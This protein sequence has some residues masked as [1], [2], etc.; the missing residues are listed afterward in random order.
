[1]S[2]ILD[3]LFHPLSNAIMT[4]LTGVTALYWITTF[5]AGDLFGDSG[6]DR[7]F[8]V[9]GADL[10]TDVAGDSDEVA[11]DQSFVQKALEFVNVG[12]VPFMMVYS[13]FK[14]VA[15]IITLASSVVLG[16]ASWGWKS[17]LTLIPVFL[18]AYVITRYATKPLVKVYHAM[19]YNG[20]EPQELLGRIGRMR[21]TISGDM[22]GAAEVKI[23]SDIVRINV[24]SKT[25][26]AIE[27][28]A[29]VMVAGESADK[30]YYLVV[31]EVNLSNIV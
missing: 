25:G 28:D 24:K 30:K 1:M 6:V 9:E 18:V 23:Q 2:G 12:K 13:V 27:Y 3:L 4:V 19:G 20:E 14:F 17:V 21:S 5:I 11:A 26:G 29:E 8:S 16:L 22:I 10:D 7:D 31:A 15:W